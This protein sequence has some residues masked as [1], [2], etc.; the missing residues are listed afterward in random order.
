MRQSILELMCKMLKP[1]RHL[2]GLLDFFISSVP[3][4]PFCF[5][6]EIILIVVKNIAFVSHCCW[7]EVVLAY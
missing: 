2:N 6:S 3:T 5:C 7:H 1:P 4:P